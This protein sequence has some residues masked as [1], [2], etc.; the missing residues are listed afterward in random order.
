MTDHTKLIEQM[1]VIGGNCG[2]SADAIEALQGEVERL[3]A[4]AAHERSLAAEKYTQT[5]HDQKQEI[6]SLQA[7]LTELEKQEPV[8]F[9]QHLNELNDK[10]L[11]KLPIGAPVYAA[12]KAPE[13][14]TVEEIERIHQRYGGD[15]VNCT[16]AIER[17]HGITK[18]TPT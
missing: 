4:Y 9:V 7:S 12:P 10:W 1:R 11:Q 8:G 2:L 6:A 17:H 5:I 3:K 18:G 15:M 13:P 14:L 16:R